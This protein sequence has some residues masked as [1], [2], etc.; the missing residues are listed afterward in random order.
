M[1]EGPAFVLAWM[2]GGTLEDLCADGP[3]APARAAEVASAVLAAL[4]EGHRRGVV[5]RAVKPAN[6]LFDAAGAPRLSDFGAAHWGD[7]SVTAT[8]G[9]FGTLAYVSP[10]LREGRPATAQSDIFAVGVLL[11]EMLTGERPSAIGPARQRPSQAHRGL[12]ESHDA[13]VDRLSA[14]AAGDRPGSAFDARALIA[15]V[16]WPEDAAPRAGHAADAAAAD[17]LDAR[18]S[19]RDGVTLDAW[20][21]RAIER[22][23]LSDAVLARARA[24][25]AADHPAL[26]TILRVDRDGSTLWLA[27]CG[28]APTRPWTDGERAAIEGARRAIEAAGIRRDAVDA[29]QVAIGGDGVVLRFAAPVVDPSSSS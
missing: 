23:P 24:F 14:P 19:T 12:D 6:V 26:Q 13:V 25:A 15:S 10:E 5:H 7:V 3:I 27:A 8:A 16:R 21:G 29:A 9:V 22:V 20:T 18:L 4:G 11:R 17:A 1:A 28:P 2:D